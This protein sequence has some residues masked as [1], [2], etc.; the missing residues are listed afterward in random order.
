MTIKSAITGKMKKEIVRMYLPKMRI[1]RSAS[2]LMVESTGNA[3]LRKIVATSDEG[4]SWNRCA[5]V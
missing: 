2:S 3:T 1:M 5:C 4:I